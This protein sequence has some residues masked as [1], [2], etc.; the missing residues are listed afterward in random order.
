MSDQQEAQPQQP[1]QEQP[2]QA[3]SLSPSAIAEMNEV[4]AAARGH[5]ENSIKDTGRENLGEFLSPKTPGRGR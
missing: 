4:A 5:V 1:Q 2:Q 3:P